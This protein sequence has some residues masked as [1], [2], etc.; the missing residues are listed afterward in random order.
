MM[1]PAVSPRW[2]F[3][4]VAMPTSAMPIVEAVVHEEPVASEPGIRSER[5]RWTGCRAETVLIRVVG[6]GH[7]WPGGWPYFG[8]R[9][10]GPMVGGWSANRVIL[11][12]FRRHPEGAP[13]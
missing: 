5:I 12:F 1:A 3:C 2:R 7:V 13:K 8:E 4:A 11:D 10:I 9:V 6:G